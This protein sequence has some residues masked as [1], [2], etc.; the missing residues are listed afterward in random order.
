V[1]DYIKNHGI[2]VLDAV[3]A[4]VDEKHQEKRFSTP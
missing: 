4:W 2:F 3:A 1:A